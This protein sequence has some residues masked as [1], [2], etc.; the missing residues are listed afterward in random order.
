MEFPLSDFNLR[1]LL[2]E[3]HSYALSTEGTMEE[4]RDRLQTARSD[5]AE[6]QAEGRVRPGRPPICKYGACV[7]PDD[8]SE[9]EVMQESEYEE[10]LKKLQWR[11]RRVNKSYLRDGMDYYHPGVLH[12]I[13]R[14]KTYTFNMC[15]FSLRQMPFI[16]KIF[17]IFISSTTEHYHRLCYAKTF[18]KTRTL[19]MTKEQLNAPVVTRGDVGRAMSNILLEIE[20]NGLENFVAVITDN[21]SV[22]LKALE[23]VNMVNRAKLPPILLDSGQLHKIFQDMFCAKSSR[24]LIQLETAHFQKSTYKAQLEKIGQNYTQNTDSAMVFE[25][26]LAAIPKVLEAMWKI[27]SHKDKP[28]SLA[29]LNNSRLNMF[30]SE[31]ENNIPPI[32]YE[33]SAIGGGVLQLVLFD[34]LWCMSIG[35]EIEEKYV[36]ETQDKAVLEFVHGPEPELD[37]DLE[38]DPDMDPDLETDLDQDHDEFPKLIL[39]EVQELM[40]EPVQAPMPGP[41]QVIIQL[42]RQDQMQ[43]QMQ[44][45][46]QASLQAS[47]QETIQATIQDLIQDPRQGRINLVIQMPPQDPLQGP[48]QGPMQEPMQ[49][50]MQQLIIEP[51]HDQMQEPMQELMQGSMQIE[52]QLEE[53]IHGPM[54]EQMQ[55]QIQG[56]MHVHTQE[57]LHEQMEEHMQEDSEDDIEE[58]IQDDMQEQMQELLTEPAQQLLPEPIQELL[59]NEIQEPIQEL[60]QDATQEPVPDNWFDILDP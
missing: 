3:L 29:L 31:A 7:Q 9:V 45:T 13:D 12:Q 41:I 19:N 28:I 11:L 26:H 38:L 44:G 46:T 14:T 35:T 25:D 2:R 1:D 48:M 20:V 17:A 16:H 37:F 8:F 15:E 59:P 4:L 55:D 54:Q 57:H 22:I 10:F 24:C 27:K 30:A 33:D 6:A 52:D 32:P 39:E 53:L 51:M 60:I 49:G 43:D 47:I 21:N 50:P 56:Q 42:P 5:E 40:Q 34:T 18:A 23:E 58:D 36:V